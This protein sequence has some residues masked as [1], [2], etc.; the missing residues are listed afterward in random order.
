M[1]DEKLEIGFA[2][3]SAARSVRGCARSVRRQRYDP[4][5]SET[6]PDGGRVTELD[7]ENERRMR[8]LIR[9][10]HPSH[11]LLG[12]ELPFEPG[13]EEWLWLLDPLDG[14][15]A[16]TVGQDTCA[17]AATLTR[18]GDPVLTA[19]AAP[20]AGE[21]YTAAHGAGTRVH[22]RAARVREPRPLHRIELLVYYDAPDPGRTALYQAAARGEV[23]RMSVVPGSFILNAART[24]RGAYH[25]YLIVKRRSGPLMP[26][27]LAPAALLFGE[28]G[29]TLRD[30]EGR[31][32]G[33]M[34]PS[35][36]VIGGSPEVV[37]EV[38]RQFGAV[39][40]DP[41][42]ELAWARRCEPA[43]ARLHARVL[44]ALGRISAQ[45]GS[46]GT[47]PGRSCLVG[48]AG[49]GG[50]IGKSSLARELAAL[51][52]EGD[53]A[54]VA[55]DDY[56]LPRAARDAK[57]VGAHDP[58]A[59]DL[60]RAASDLGRLREG[61]SAEKPVYDHVAGAPLRTEAVEPRR[62][63]LVEGVQAL[64]PAL[65]PLLD[66]AVFLDATPGVRFRRVARDVEE[67][68]VSESYARAV[69]ERFEEDI[70]RFLIPLRDAADV[71]VRVD[72][73]FELLWLAPA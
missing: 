31:P 10:R 60:A 47:L 38:I 58:E 7:R 25:A 18:R 5:V 45:A 68:E 46:P 9:S 71:V 44:E 59:S 3:A 56:L 23:G 64:H 70:R 52:G 65:R 48:I 28:A 30:L 57:G 72:E 12:E 29:G 15:R 43:F 16:F 42:V 21:L 24:A 1:A 55:L 67:K 61:R 49:A 19:V 62:F 17:V 69:F 26:W 8:A 66:L 32:V 54:V 41:G 33:G 37:A 39:I 35:R 11:A 63:V 20:L 40:R 50:G 6:K 34:I 13:V 73:S 27:D 36:E 22:G 4:P 51:L 14:T 53:S 2:A